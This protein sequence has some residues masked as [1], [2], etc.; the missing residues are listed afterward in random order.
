MKKTLNQITKDMDLK[1]EKNIDISKLELVAW[2]IVDEDGLEIDVYQVYEVRKDDWEKINKQTNLP[3]FKS[4]NW[5]FYIWIDFYGK[6][7]DDVEYD[8]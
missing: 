8:A 6:S 4:K 1:L 2:E 5:K 3:L 7:W